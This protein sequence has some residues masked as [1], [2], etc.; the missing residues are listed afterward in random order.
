MI[1]LTPNLRA[2][3]LSLPCIYLFLAFVI[4][5][6]AQSSLIIISVSLFIIIMALSMFLLGNRSAFLNPLYMF[7]FL[8]LTLYSLNWLPFL[9]STNLVNDTYNIV[10]FESNRVESAIVVFNLLTCLWLI[11][12]VSGHLMWKV[13][14]KWHAVDVG[15]NY[16]SIAILVIL[17]SLFSLLMLIDKAGSI[18]EL[19]IQRE[20]SREDRLAATIGRHWFAFAQMGILGLALWAFSDK[21][22]FTS[23]YFLPI[24]ALTLLTGF[25][26]SGNRTSIVMSFVLIYVA[27]AFNSKKLISPMIVV[28]ALGLFVTLSAATLVRE[29][30]FSKLLNSGYENMENEVGFIEKLVQIRTERAINGSASL[31]VLIAL[32]SGKPFI[33]GES[34]KSI[35]YIPIPSAVLPGPKP[36][37]AGR[38]AAKELS[39]RTDTAWPVSPVVEA[40][41]NFGF[42]GVMLSGLIFGFLSSFIYRIMVNNPNSTILLVGYF[43]FITTFSLSSDGFYKFFQVI[44][45]LAV[46][47]FIL[48]LYILI[49][50]KILQVGYNRY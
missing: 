20:L 39:G 31:G 30:G 38:L 41:W 24:F 37:A 13:K 15:F 6:S 9:F 5:F 49:R 10:G 22:L 45:P 17:L 42:L 29:V 18:F 32:D 27:W 19:M 11:F 14:T 28:I 3:I 7:C 4:S 50:K 36:P 44:I 43:S 16:R 1:E 25:I 23:W 46:L 33:G 40:Y 48:K 35:A 12:A 21:K 8:Q 47:Y 34:Y 2:L 26:V